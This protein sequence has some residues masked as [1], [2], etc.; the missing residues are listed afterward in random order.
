MSLSTKFFLSIGN[1][2]LFVFAAAMAAGTAALG[3]PNK[4]EDRRA[5]EAM[6]DGIERHAE[7]LDSFAVTGLLTL[8]YAPRPDAPPNAITGTFDYRFDLRK[9]GDRHFYEFELVGERAEQERAGEGT[10][11]HVLRRFVSNGERSEQLTINGAGKPG[12]QVAEEFDW[13]LISIA[14]V[15]VG[16]REQPVRPFIKPS[17]WKRF[18]VRDFTTESIVLAHDVGES[19]EL[20]YWSV[21]H[22]ENLPRLDRIEARDEATDRLYMRGIAEDFATLSVNGLTLELPR[23]AVYKHYLLPDQNAPPDQEPPAA[24]VITLTSMNWTLP[25]PHDD[26]EDFLMLWPRGTAVIDRRLKFVFVTAEDKEER[27]TDSEIFALGVD[28]LKRLGGSRSGLE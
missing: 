16:L 19:D 22:D 14:D 6:L 25:N 3:Q 13:P 28:E 7:S 11:E 15:I 12:G 17:D 2:Y 5:T 24:L 1:P 23:R 26:P 18:D 8:T 27:V 4:N 9:T 21:R 10:D 20:W